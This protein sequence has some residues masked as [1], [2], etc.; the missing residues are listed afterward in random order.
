MRMEGSK[1]PRQ[2]E[3]TARSADL[4][5][6]VAP[7]V[8]GRVLA[9]VKTAA[10]DLVARGLYHTGVLSGLRGVPQSYEWQPRAGL[11]RVNKPKFV[12]LCYHRVGSG[13]VPLFSAL[14]PRLFE[15]Q[16]RYL[17]DNYRIVSLD[18]LY[19][20]CQEPAQAKPAVVVT[21][22]DGYRDL[23][24]YAFPALR[25]YQVPATIYLVAGS[26]ESGE[27]PWYD[28]V[29]LL[30]R[31]SP[32]VLDL[33]R[34]GLGQWELDDPQS[35]LEAAWTLICQMRGMPD[36]KRQQICEAL[37]GMPGVPPEDLR[38]RMLTWEQIREMQSE[39]IS[40]GGHTM[41][42]PVVSQLGPVALEYELGD[43]KQL[44]ES[45][46]QKAVTDFAYPF[47]K[48]ED[49]G[50]WA[51]QVLARFGYR[52]AATT[53]LGVN[54]PLTHCYSLRRMQIGDDGSVATFAFDLWRLMLESAAAGDGAVARRGSSLVKTPHA[55]A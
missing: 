22:D 23:Y 52:T 20:E 1:V 11:R 32:A 13:G 37:A 45:R 6:A 53:V 28:R 33:S 49:C 3:Q 39:G 4:C 42:H 31:H 27:V 29:F 48:P 34:F 18:Q 40:F 15:A 14:S 35:S 19:R 50:S 2:R 5:A 10:R 46:L 17:R 16:M 54:S 51:P 26:I 36:S 55:I 25:K 44:L 12:I 38:D 8:K 7:T 24:R 47:G 43:S 41:T 30:F 9:R 21:F